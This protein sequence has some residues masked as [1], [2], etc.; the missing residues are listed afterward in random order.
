VRKARLI[1][2]LAAANIPFADDA[3]NQ[4][5][6]FVRTR[7]RE[8]MPSLAGE[9]LDAER[10]ALLARRLV[11]ADIAL[12]DA[13]DRAM[14]DLRIPNSG[15]GSI[16]LD[17]RRFVLL[18][19]EIGIRLLG[20][21]IARLGYEGALRLGQVEAL[22]AAIVDAKQGSLRRTLAGALVTLRSAKLVVARAPPRRLTRIVARP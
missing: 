11:R 20:R 14:Q 19:A 9:G 16:T 18:P 22:Y 6:R 5:V 3:S 13:A 4:D 1:A 21:A 10:L 2:T 7:W 15:E 12:E 8:L 17:A